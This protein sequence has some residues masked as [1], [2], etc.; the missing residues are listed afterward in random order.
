MAI[1]KLRPTFTF[2]QK[3]GRVTGKSAIIPPV[4]VIEEAD[5]AGWGPPWSL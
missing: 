4:D 1:S 3:L 5:R 2:D